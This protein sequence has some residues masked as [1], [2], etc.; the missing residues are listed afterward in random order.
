MNRRTIAKTFIPMVCLE[1]N[2]IGFFN[3][4]WTYPTVNF[5]IQ[6]RISILL[7]L[8]AFPN[9]RALRYIFFAF[10]DKKGCR[11]HP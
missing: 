1:M 5:P 2:K 4:S 11:C 9:G 8:R 7:F 3:T 10:Q 6:P